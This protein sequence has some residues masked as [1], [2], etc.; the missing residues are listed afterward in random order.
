VDLRRETDIEQLRRVALAQQVQIEQLLRVLRAKSDELAALKG[1]DA[2]LQQTLSLIED[3]TRRAQQAAATVAATDGVSPS[4]GAAEKKPRKPREHFGNTEQPALPV[5]E[6][7]FELDDAD[8]TCPQCGGALSPMKGQF[9]TSEMVDVVEV[10]Y[11]VVKVNQQKYVCRCGACIE[12]APGPERATPGG[13]YSLDF[14][15]KVAIDKYLDHIPLARQERILRR[16]GLEV[17][18][19]T[20]WDQLN[21]L[22]RRLES[23]SRALLA[24]VLAEPVVG[25]DQTGWPRLDG[26][27]G[28]P[29]QMW[30]LTAPGAVVHRIRDD[31]GTD[32]FR[33]LMGDYAGVVVCD[34]LKTHE[35]GARG[36]DRIAL[37]G[38]WAHV[39][40]KFEEAAPDHPEA[41]LALKWIGD[42]YA[43]DD[44]AEGDLARMAQ[45]RRTESAE[46]IATMKT[47]L[48]NQATLKTLS[49]GNAAA[50]VVANWDR[51]TRFLGDARIPLDNNATERGIRG[52]VVGRKNH[53]GSK[54]RRGTEIAAIFYTLLETA[55]LAGIHP[56]AYLRAA[57]IADARGEV[58]LPG[59][60]TTESPVNRS[61]GPA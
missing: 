36:N 19:Q 22:G 56:A 2:E 31:K 7:T 53:Y 39:Y 20:L 4:A 16:H 32:T 12:T 10:S 14:A 35:A 43:L 57:A 54:S 13:R 61:P 11:R 34:A 48:W 52:P 47:W 42:L 15:I 28:K 37:A 27:S 3:L 9:D 40:R 33:A 24:R 30:C 23:A 44:R 58:L 55:K 1:N 6:Q 49:I 46:V 60:F 41:H 18:T 51:L 17:T 29:W 5:I 45:L 25:L 8:K 50:Y 21:A 38:C 59:D 26:K